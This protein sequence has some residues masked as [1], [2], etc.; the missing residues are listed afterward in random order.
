MAEASLAIGAVHRSSLIACKGSRNQEA[1]HLPV[2]GM[3]AYGNA[4]HLLPTQLP[5][6]TTFTLHRVVEQ[7]H[8]V[9]TIAQVFT[10]LQNMLETMFYNH[11]INLNERK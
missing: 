5:K 3:K 6:V 9:R 11:V 4:L 2:M 8:S 1:S 10:C 7:G